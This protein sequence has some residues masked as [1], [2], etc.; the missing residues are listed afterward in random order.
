MAHTSSPPNSWLIAAICFGFAAASAATVVESPPGPHAVGFRVVQQFDPSRR[1]EP[2]GR[3]GDPSTGASVSARP[4]QTLIWYPAQRG[5]PSSRRVR[6]ADYVATRFSE[7]DFAL[8]PEALDAALARQEAAW[9][10]RLGDGAARL[11]ASERPVQRNAVEAEGRFPVIVYA[12]GG[13]GFAD[14]N[15]D[16]L[17]YLASHGYVVLASTSL[18]VND[19]EIGDTMASVEPQVADVRFL[20]DYAARVPGADPDHLAVVGWSWGGMVNVFA[21]SRD[22]RIDAIVSLDGTREPALTRRIDVRRLVVPWLYVSRS[23]DTIPEINRSGIDTTFSLL[24]E[25]RHADV[26]QLIMYPM[27]HV[28]F[29][30]RRLH[31]SSAASYGEYTRGEIVQAYGMMAQYVR[32]YL[33][34]ALK[35]SAEGERFLAR[36]PRENGAVPHSLR[37][38]RRAAE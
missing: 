17:E 21:A 14:E 33:D 6:Y 5:D 11:L 30:S 4:V 19:K 34:V 13:G 23:P 9:R 18:A 35:G 28:D 38:E 36:T 29:I 3:S 15:A 7:T 22:E 31:E 32:Y 12:A 16:L 27:Q 20:V 1:F 26:D 2:N 24:N 8:A 10:P 25:A 37:W